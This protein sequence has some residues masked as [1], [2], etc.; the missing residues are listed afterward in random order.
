MKR[1]YHPDRMDVVKIADCQMEYDGTPNEL[2]NYLANLNAAIDQG[3]IPADEK[4]SAVTYVYRYI[5]RHDYVEWRKRMGLS[6]PD[7]WLV[8][9]DTGQCPDNTT[10]PR[11][12]GRPRNPRALSN[13]VPEIRHDAEEV[14]RKI[15][16]SPSI[17]TVVKALCQDKYEDR[18]FSRIMRLLRKTW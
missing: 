9:G 15:G 10:Q 8:E 13:R 16:G 12:S 18:Q 7:W 4:Q 6:P 3:E 1:S 17:K 5:R 14:A 2:N 11:P